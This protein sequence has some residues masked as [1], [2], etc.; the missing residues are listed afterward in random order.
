M[1]QMVGFGYD[2]SIDDYKIVRISTSNFEYCVDKYSLE[3]NSWK[4]I[5]LLLKAN[6]WKTI[7]RQPDYMVCK[8]YPECEVYLK[9]FIYWL[10]YHSIICF[11]LENERFRN[12][13]WHDGMKQK[14][15]NG[16]SVMMGGFLV[17]HEFGAKETPLPKAI[18]YENAL[19]QRL[20]L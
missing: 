7:E 13:L 11:D 20:N 15:H 14:F 2:L 8:N 10:E 3:A 6:Y 19:F 4:I 5:P 18:G 12:V 17:F 1:Y 16:L 9:G